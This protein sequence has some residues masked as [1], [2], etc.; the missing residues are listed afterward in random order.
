MRLF[1]TKSI[2]FF[3]LLV[4]T[5]ANAQIPDTSSIDKLLHYILQPLDKSQ[6]ISIGSERYRINFKNLIITNR[7]HTNQSRFLSY[8]NF[9][10]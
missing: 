2:L 9:N 6:P 3:S 8:K 5:K 1:I 4:A 10:L 7:T